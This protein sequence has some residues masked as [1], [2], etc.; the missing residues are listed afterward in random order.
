MKR[1]VRLSFKR[2]KPLCLEKVKILNL[3]TSP[4]GHL[5][6]FLG[7]CRPSQTTTHAFSFIAKISAKALL[8]KQYFI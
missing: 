2:R 7:G 1:H 5:R 8:P 4:Y 6:Y 3:Q